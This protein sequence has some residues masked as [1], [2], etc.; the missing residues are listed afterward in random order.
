MVTEAIYKESSE[1][2]GGLKW[3]KRGTTIIGNGLGSGPDQLNLP[4]GIFIELK[5]QILYVADMSNSRIQK[6]YQN[7]VIKTAAGQS[8]GTS[9]KAANM[10]SGPADVFADENENI[11][12]ADWGNQRIQ[13]WEKDAKFGKTIAGNGSQGSA[14]NEFSFP[15]TVFFDSK[16]N[17]IGGNG[18]GLNPYQLNGPTGLYYDEQN[19]ILYIS[20]EQSHSITQW[21]LGS[22]EPRNIYAGIP[23][24][25]GNS[26]AQLFYPEGITMDKYGNLYVADTSNHRIQMF[27]PNAIQGITIA[28]TGQLGN[29]SIE[30][31]YPGDIAFDSELNLYVSDRYNSRI[32]K[33]RRTQ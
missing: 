19:Q 2:P 21:V 14:L 5:T 8:N 13:Y 18:A 27:C 3:S 25:P 6:R 17:I 12:I 4:D 30:L 10:L 9:G 24:R 32:Q 22:Y 23:G 15:S 33:F 26:A 31:S 28:G 29:S 7:G 20:N 11:F 16:K 1:C